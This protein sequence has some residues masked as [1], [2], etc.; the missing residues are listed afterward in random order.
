MLAESSWVPTSSL[1]PCGAMAGDRAGSTSSRSGLG[2]G[3]TSPRFLAALFPAPLRRPFRCA[4]DAVAAG[5]LAVRSEGWERYGGR[6][7]VF[8]LFIFLFWGNDGS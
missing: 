8:I 6:G 4:S 7:K 2:G 1:R 5:W 3:T